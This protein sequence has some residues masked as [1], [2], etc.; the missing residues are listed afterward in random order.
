MTTAPLCSPSPSRASSSTLRARTYSGSGAPGTFVPG[1][2]LHEF[3]RLAG[4]ASGTGQQVG[5]VLAWCD[6]DDSVSLPIPL[7]HNRIE[8]LGQDDVGTDLG[9]AYGE[10]LGGIL[11]VVDEKDG[12][13]CGRHRS[14]ACRTE[15][16]GHGVPEVR[17][18]DVVEHGVEASRFQVRARVIASE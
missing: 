10:A 3:F 14:D 2:P 1:H 9:Q 18:A 12:E 13:A 16:T 4:T 11:D 8:G 5:C 17:V 15:R 6:V 7:V